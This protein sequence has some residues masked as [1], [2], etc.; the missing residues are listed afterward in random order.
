L[1]DEV[2][3]PVAQGVDLDGEVGLQPL[4]LAKLYEAVE[5][6]LPVA[7]AGEIV[8]GDEEGL[9]SLGDILAH[10]LLEV[11]GGAEAALASLDVDDRAEAALERAASA[12]IEARPLAGIP[13]E[14]FLRHPGEGHAGD[15]RKVLEVVVDGLQLAFPGVEEQ[16]VEPPLLGLPGEQG[17][18]DVEGLPH[19][20]RN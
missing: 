2:R 3:D 13:L 17:A 14:R 20:G 7:V 8:V 18:A 6:F 15:A 11:V 1:V 10:D 12:E 19:F 16:G 9:Y 4:L 5:E